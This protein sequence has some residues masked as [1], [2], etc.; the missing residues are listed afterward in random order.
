MGNYDVMCTYMY[1]K[2]YCFTRVNGYAYARKPVYMQSL[3]MANKYLIIYTT[4]YTGGDQM[5][6]ARARGSH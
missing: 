2:M 3:C 1:I 4:L 5:T 6:G